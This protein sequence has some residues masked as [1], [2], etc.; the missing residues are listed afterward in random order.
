M[1][2][3]IRSTVD[4]FSTPPL[5][6]TYLSTYHVDYFPISPITD[7][8]ISSVIEFNIGGTESYISLDDTYLYLKLM[9]VKANGD[10]LTTYVPGVPQVPGGAAAVAALGDN[11]AFVN[12]IG[13]SLFSQVDI[14]LNE[15]LITLNSSYYSYK[16]YFEK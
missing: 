4:L 14:Y 16:N 12:L 13:G 6:N 8:T 7:S 15:Y 11:V 1:D 10:D 3:V 5:E 2:S 9:L